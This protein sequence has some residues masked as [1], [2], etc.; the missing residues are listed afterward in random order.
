MKYLSLV[1]ILSCLRAQ[2]QVGVKSETSG[3]IFSKEELIEDIQ[4]YRNFHEK[5]NTNLYAYHSKAYIDSVFDGLENNVFPMDEMSFFRYM[6][7]ATSSISDGHCLLFPPHE[8]IAAADTLQGFFPFR[9]R[10]DQGAFFVTMDLSDSQNYY[11]SR[12]IPIDAIN[13]VASDSIYDIALRSLPREGNNLQYPNWILEKYFY[14]YYSYVFG[15]PDTF[16]LTTFCT[17]P[18]GIKNVCVSAKIPAVTKDTLV[19][20][21]K[22]RY[23]DYPMTKARDNGMSFTRYDSINAAVFSLFTWD[24]T[25]L[26]KVYGIHFKDSINTYMQ[27]AIDDSIGTLIIDLRNNQGGFM[28]YGVYVM[29]WLMDSTFNYIDKIERVHRTS[30]NE[31][32]YKS[33]NTGRFKSVKP[34]KHNYGGNVIILTNGGTFSN[35]S[36]FTTQM[37]RYGR[38]VVM[39]EETGGSSSQLTGSF[40]V[41]RPLIMPNSKIELS[42]INYRIVVNKDVPYSGKGVIPDIAIADDWN[43]ENGDMLLQKVLKEYLPK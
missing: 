33:V 16:K 25:I 21:R 5:H 36:I 14:E 22:N 27:T 1:L 37:Q 26:R 9:I 10:Y 30:S 41:H 32:I 39:G 17:S 28:M 12:L 15:H 20:R 31:R 13:G 2:S 35:S 7:I 40:G 19:A 23:P 34:Y 6:S 29:R 24:K 18:D 11:S 4:Y 43:P 3:V 42:H 38:A 8:Q